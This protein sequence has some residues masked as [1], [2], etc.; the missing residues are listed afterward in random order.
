[1]AGLVAVSAVIL[2]LIFLLEKAVCLPVVWLTTNAAFVLIV[3]VIAVV[4]LI[5]PSSVLEAVHL[6][7]ASFIA[8]TAHDILAVVVGPA[9][10]ESNGLD[11][12]DRK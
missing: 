8:K 3:I 5:P 10:F 4:G 9:H 6:L 12:F 2:L 7:V 1:M 11:G